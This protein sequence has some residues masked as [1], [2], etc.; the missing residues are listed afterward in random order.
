M[1][2]PGSVT[3]G[4]PRF[5]CTSFYPKVYPIDLIVLALDLP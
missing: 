4:A 1:I 5:L 3:E 2:A